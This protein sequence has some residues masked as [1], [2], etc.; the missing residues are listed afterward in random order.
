MF[1]IRKA[2]IQHKCLIC[3]NQIKPKT[4]YINFNKQNPDGTYKT[5]AICESCAE[6]I[7]VSAIE[8]D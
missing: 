6:D 7:F 4:H 5:G 1:K 2:K 3:N 8:R